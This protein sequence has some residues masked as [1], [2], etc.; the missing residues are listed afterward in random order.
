[1]GEA[2]N[3][4]NWHSNERSGWNGAGY[5]IGNKMWYSVLAALLIVWMTVDATT[6]REAIETIFGFI[7]LGVMIYMPFRVLRA[8]FR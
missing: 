1:M 3:D 4:E 7:I 8:I 5:R 6:V 2:A